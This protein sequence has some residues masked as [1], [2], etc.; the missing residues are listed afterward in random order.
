M[1]SRGGLICTDLEAVLAEGHCGWSTVS[2]QKTVRNAVEELGRALTPQ[3][4]VQIYS[5]DGTRSFKGGQMHKMF[6]V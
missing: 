6:M 3:R 4:G 5:K 1:P 2:D